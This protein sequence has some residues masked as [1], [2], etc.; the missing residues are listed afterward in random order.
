MLARGSPRFNMLLSKGAQKKKSPIATASKTHG[1]SPKGK[2]RANWNSM[3][4]KTLVDLLHEHN[5]PEYKGNNGWT[6]DAWNK[7]AKEFQERERYA[8]FSKVQIQEK[9]KELKRDYRMLKDARKQSGVSWDE[10]RCMIQADPPIWDNIIK[11]FPRA[12]KFRNKSFPLFEALGELHDGN[13]AE[14]TYNF[15]STQPNG[16]DLTQI[17]S[18]DVPINIEDREDV[19]DPLAD[20]RQNE[21][22]DKVY[23]VEGVDVN[24]DR[25]DER[26]KRT[27]VVSRNEE[28]KGL[29][30][31]KKSSNIEVLMERYLNIRSKQAE[32]ETTQLAREREARGG[33]DFSIKNCIAVL[34]TLEVTKEEKVKAYK[35]FKDP[36]NR[37]IFLS[38][39]NDDREAALM[40]LRDEMA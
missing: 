31:P 26:S 27:F 29:K 34:N 8:G 2:T 39:C 6:P 38:A 12:K 5:T 37:Q 17:G 15:T 1:G 20:H 21:V 14:G 9:E 4:E 10:K 18:G 3:L 25:Q 32:D 13:T 22:E 23:E 7:I 11:S 33:D 40:W 36:D 19:G 16:P 35:V 30:R 24:A 28:E